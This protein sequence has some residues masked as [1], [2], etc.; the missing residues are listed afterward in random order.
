MTVAAMAQLGELGRSSS[1]E[2]Y[3]KST[4]DNI[5]FISYFIYIVFAYELNFVGFFFK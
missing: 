5:T 3:V 2:Y 1:V 4:Y